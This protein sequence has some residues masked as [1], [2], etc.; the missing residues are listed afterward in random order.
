[1]VH[2]A[3]LIIWQSR[4]AFAAAGFSRPPDGSRPGAGDQ[5]SIRGSYA[6][7]LGIAGRLFD[8]A[9]GWWIAQRT[10]TQLLDDI[11]VYVEAQYGI[12]RALRFRKLSGQLRRHREGAF[13]TNSQQNCRV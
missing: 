1:M 10:L 9:I 2:E 11:C 4:L 6:R 8:S 13:L 7:P 5:M 3:L 12:E